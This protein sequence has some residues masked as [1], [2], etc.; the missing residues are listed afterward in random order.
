MTEENVRFQFMIVYEPEGKRDWRA[1]KMRKHYL[2]QGR[3]CK[4]KARNSVGDGLKE[5]NSNMKCFGLWRPALVFGSGRSLGRV[6]CGIS[7]FPFSLGCI[8][9]CIYIWFIL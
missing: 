6:A 3:K 5:R 7:F 4:L 2:K 1:L 9:I 8:C